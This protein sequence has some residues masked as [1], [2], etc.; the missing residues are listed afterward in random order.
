MDHLLLRQDSSGL[1]YLLI[2]GAILEQVLPHARQ[3]EKMRSVIQKKK[4]KEYFA[5]WPGR[6]KSRYDNAKGVTCQ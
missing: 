4:K 6:L 2:G 3:W 1:F 5:D